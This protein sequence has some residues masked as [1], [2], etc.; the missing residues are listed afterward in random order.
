[1]LLRFEG[2]RR[3]LLFYSL[4]LVELLTH[5]GEKRRRR[6]FDTRLN[7][8]FKLVDFFLSS[9]VEIAIK[10]GNEVENLAYVATSH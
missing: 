3:H 7:K 2:R 10:N 9:R 5:G 8:Y 1:M 4:E 6:R